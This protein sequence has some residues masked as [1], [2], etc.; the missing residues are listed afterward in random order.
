MG[1]VLKT[2]DRAAEALVAGNLQQAL[3]LLERAE[4]QME[5]DDSSVRDD[6]RG[7]LMRMSSLAAASAQGIA[8]ARQLIS[9]ALSLARNVTTYDKSGKAR[10]V[11]RAKP[12]IGRF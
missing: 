5:A 8:D 2:L 9:E 6:V 11:K 1:D 10:N 7:R 3:D 4:R 12:V